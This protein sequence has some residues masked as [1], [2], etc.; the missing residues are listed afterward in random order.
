M[1]HVFQ[2]FDAHGSFLLNIGAQGR[3]TGEFWLP[4]G[5][6]IGRQDT[7]YVADAYN[8]RVQVF[9]YVGGQP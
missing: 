9:R 4:S 1:F 7:I 5:I 8:Q 6:F 3:G 2:I